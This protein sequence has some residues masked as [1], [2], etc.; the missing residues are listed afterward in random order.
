M[1]L[2]YSRLFHYCIS[3]TGCLMGKNTISLE[4]YL[5]QHSW[6]VFALALWLLSDFFILWGCWCWFSGRSVLDSILNNFSF[7]LKKLES[8]TRLALLKSTQPNC[9]AARRSWFFCQMQTL[10]NLF[11]LWINQLGFIRTL[12]G[13]STIKG[14]CW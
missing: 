5:F 9:S 11:N 2:N 7:N 10:N 13:F 14:K 1:L 12:K 4:R 3:F 6:F 8:L